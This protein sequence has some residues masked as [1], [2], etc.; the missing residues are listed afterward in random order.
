MFPN[1]VVSRAWTR[2]NGRCE[3]CGKLLTRGNRGRSGRGCWE[4]HHSNPARKGGTDSLRNCRILCW[5]CH[6]K[7][8]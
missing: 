1:D 3:K 5:E 8:F 2:T 4:A 7:T 6:S